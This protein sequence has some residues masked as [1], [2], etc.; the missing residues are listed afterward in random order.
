MNSSTVSSVRR[1]NGTWS[2]CRKVVGRVLFRHVRPFMDDRFVNTQWNE[3][4][5]LHPSSVKW[6]FSSHILHFISLRFDSF[7]RVSRGGA[8][9]IRFF[10]FWLSD[11]RRIYATFAEWRLRVYVDRQWIYLLFKFDSKLSRGMICP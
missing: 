5:P 3:M 8:D 7:A 1:W 6:T 10:L 9:R 2:Y 4:I 11:E